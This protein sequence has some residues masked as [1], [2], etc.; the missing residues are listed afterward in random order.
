MSGGR[1]KG[2]WLVFAPLIVL[3]ALAFVLAIAVSNGPPVRKSA[4]IGKPAPAFDLPPVEGMSQPGL[5]RA[6]LGNGRPVIVNF[7]ASWCLPCR[8][9]QP[10]LEALARASGIELV[11]INYKD[12]PAA[13]A[14]F[15]ATYG[16]PFARIGRDKDGRAGI[17]WGISG[18]PETFYVGSDGRILAHREGP[19]DARTAVRWAKR[20]PASARPTGS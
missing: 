14:R 1:E 15:L 10:A 4:L 3:A 6:D 2:R 13:A 17:E 5:A 11:G 9:E 7:W 16:N 19:I 20:P 8:E 18:V 12:E